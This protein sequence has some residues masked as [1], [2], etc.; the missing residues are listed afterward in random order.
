[1]GWV[2]MLAYI[3]GTVD[4]ELLFAQRI[5]RGREL[6]AGVVK[7]DNFRWQ[8]RCRGLYKLPAAACISIRHPHV[9]RHDP[10]VMPR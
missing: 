3:T 8:A 6:T 7:L 5:P 2:R 9:S 10:R 1:M 4:Q